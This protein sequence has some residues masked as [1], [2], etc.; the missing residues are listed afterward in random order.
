MT[1]P[2][3]TFITFLT[4]EE[5]IQF[6]QKVI[7]IIK[8]NTFFTIRNLTT[9]FG[10]VLLDYFTWG[11]ARQFP[12]RGA[13]LIEIFNNKSQQFNLGFKIRKT[14]FFEATKHRCGYKLIYKQWKSI[15]EM[16]LKKVD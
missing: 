12:L 11:T 16:S 2:N 3:K 9:T 10:I 13:K 15:K 1:T 8:P 4:E 14:N 6:L 5:T 7:S